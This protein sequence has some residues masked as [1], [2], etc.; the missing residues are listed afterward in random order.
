MSSSSVG[1]WS[2][3]VQ[4][5]GS[6]AYKGYL[7]FNVPANIP[8]ASMSQVSLVVNFKGTATSKQKWMWSIY[9]W[10]KK[11]WVELGTASG[12]Q[13]QWQLLK[14]K[15]PMRKEYGSAG[16]EVR[17]QLRS[18]NEN[19]DA[20]V[21]YQVLLLMLGSPASAQKNALPAATN[22]PASSPTIVLPA[23]TDTP[24]IVDPNSTPTPHAH[25]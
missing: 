11:E 18:N 15:I 13:N 4:T 7:S 17:I 14:F 5:P 16:N 2:D 25:P 10:N 19:G 8:A 20:K 3:R 6:S 23:A 24:A 1:I 12:T 22:I 9:N 21:D